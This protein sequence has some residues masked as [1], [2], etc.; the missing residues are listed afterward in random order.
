MSDYLIKSVAYEG[1]LRIYVLDA[2]ETIREAQERHDTWSASTAALG[3]TM[4]GSIMLGAMLKGD[5]KLTVRL[6]G[7]GPVGYIVVDS[8]GKGQVKGYI[9][10]PHVSLP[11][12]DQGKIDV[13][14]AVGTEGSLTVTKDLGMKEPFSGQVPL[15]SGEIGEDFTYYMA[16]SEQT[17]SAVGVSVLVNPDE[18]VKSAGGFMIQVMPGAEESTIDELE[19]RLQ[20]IPLVSKLMDS[21]EKP[22]EILDRLVGKGNSKILE[23]LPVQ[24]HCGCSKERFAEALVTLPDADINEMIEKD[25]GAEAVCHFCGEKYHFD[26]EELEQIKKQSR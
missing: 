23:T 10:N 20:S 21:G 7:N 11:L 25:Q 2:T 12:N 24:F 1:Q 22:E 3:R 26:E 18:T 19:E 15:V 17:P 8:N 14:G 9:V 13:K 16:T 4:I 5:E 6:T